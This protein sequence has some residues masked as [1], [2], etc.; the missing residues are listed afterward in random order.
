VPESELKPDDLELGWYL[1][2]LRDRWK[3]L[4]VGAVL[5]AV[6]GIAPT[7]LGPTFYEASTTLLVVP[8]P[9]ASALPLNPATFRAI[10]VNGTV[11][12][13]IVDELALRNPPHNLTPPLFLERVNVEQ[14]AGTNVLRLRVALRDPDLAAEAT[15]RVAQKILVLAEELNDAEVA[16]AQNPLKSRLAETSAR[17]AAA[18]TELLTYQQR[19]H[20]DLLEEDMRATIKER[21]RKLGEAELSRLNELYARRVELARLQADFKLAEKIHSDLVV[22]YENIQTRAASNSPQLRLVDRAVSPGAPIPAGRR[23]P[24]L[25]GL[26]AGALAAGLVALWL[27][28]RQMRKSGNQA[29][30]V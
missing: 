15:R 18:E 6:V 16:S 10:L 5:G 29:R 28:G 19:A 27:E 21:G 2:A 22:H 7:Y 11:A 23:R 20:V 30:Q 25:L 3:L 12:Q 8:S 1:R 9:D 4:L 26:I 13:Q 14:V 24:L 17:M